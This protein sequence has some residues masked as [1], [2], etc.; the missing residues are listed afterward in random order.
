MLNLDFSPFPIL[1]TDRLILQ[2]ITDAHA[3]ALFEMR[4][5]PTIMRY[6]DRPIPTSIEEVKE[7]IQKMA[8]M[9]SAGEGIS[10]GIFKKDNPSVKIGN[11]GLYRII[12]AHY[13]AEIGYMLTTNE[14]Q[15]GIMFEA[16]Q[17]VIEFG[18]SQIQLHSMEAN[19]NPANLASKKLLEKAGF[20]RE[21]YFKENYFFN[22]QF[23]DSEIYSLLNTKG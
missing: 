16:M 15:K 19:I 5:D 22:G 9:K 2:E 12:A 6:I 17:K 18:F 10:W 14:H 13:R 20:V 7:L 21:A 8:T 1:E 3:P 4:T 23:I 11:I